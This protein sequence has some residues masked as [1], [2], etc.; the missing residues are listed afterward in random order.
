MGLAVCTFSAC[1]DDDDMNQPTIDVCT[2]V[3]NDADMDGEIDA[4][5]RQIM[6]SCLAEQLTDAEAVKNNL[7]GQWRL[8]GYGNSWQPTASQPCAQLTF[9]LNHLIVDFEDGT[10]DAASTHSW[11]IAEQGNGQFRI[12]A[13]PEVVAGELPTVFCSDYIYVNSTPVDG[14]VYI[15]E[16]VIE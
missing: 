14:N 16:K 12:Q 11:S 3:Q 2:F 1:Q 4:T 6:E 13:D 5:E 9:T 8:V 7:I 15:Y 10:T